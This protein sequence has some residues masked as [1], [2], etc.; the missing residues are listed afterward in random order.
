MIFFNVIGA[1]VAL[2]VSEPF[3]RVASKRTIT[4]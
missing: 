4:E 3:V 1:D 2:H